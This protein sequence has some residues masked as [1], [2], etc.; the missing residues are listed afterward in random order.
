[1]FG[2]HR[3][4]KYYPNPMQFDPDRFSEKNSEGKNNINRPYMPFGEGP[5]FCIGMRLGK[6]QAQ[7]GL[8]AM[9]QRYTFSLETKEQEKELIFDSGVFLLTPIHDIRLRASKR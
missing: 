9:L 5:R 7:V 8:I 1:M 3:D 6:M 4:E 2:I